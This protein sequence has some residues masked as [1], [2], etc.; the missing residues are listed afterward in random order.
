MSILFTTGPPTVIANA[1]YLVFTRT[2]NV[3]TTTI[4]LWDNTGNTTLST[5][6]LGSSANLLNSQCAVGTTTQTVVGDSVQFSIQIVFF[7]PAFS[8]PKSVYLDATEPNS[9]SGFVY[10]GSW[11]VQ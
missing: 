9:S 11:T 10:A 1:C 7:K 3:Q 4:G 5:K 6:L 8:G 2:I